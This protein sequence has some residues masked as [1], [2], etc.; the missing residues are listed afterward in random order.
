MKRAEHK[1]LLEQDAIRQVTVEGRC[2][3]G[4]VEDDHAIEWSTDGG[5]CELCACKNWRE[6][7]CIELAEMVADRVLRLLPW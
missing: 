5:A 3:C 7:S 6:P 4:H 2:G 1:R